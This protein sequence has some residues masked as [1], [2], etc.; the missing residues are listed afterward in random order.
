M[1]ASIKKTTVRP[2]K[3]KPA[4]ANQDAISQEIDDLAMRLVEGERQAL[5]KAITLIESTRGDHREKAETLLQR[6]MPQTGGAVRLG[7][8]GAP[9]VGKSTFV[10]AFG[11]YL[12]AHDLKVAVLAID[13]SS[14]RSGGSILGDKTRMEELARDSRAFIRPSPSG[15]SLGGV[16]RRT[17]ETLLLAEAAGFDVVIV[18]TV[19]VGQSETMVADMVD[20]FLLLLSPAGGDELQG[21]KRGIMELADLVIVTKADG[22]LIPAARRAAIQCKAALSFMQPKTEY[23]RAEVLTVSALKGQGMEEIWQ[24]VGAHHRSFTSTNA[25]SQLRAAQAVAA[26]WREVEETMLAAFKENPEVK[27]QVKLME[28]TVSGGTMTPSTAARQLLGLFHRG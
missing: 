16:A 4:M 20:M 15:G 8:S 12:T 13:P 19:G 2:N 7:L 17:R 1:T 27:S 5:A 22:E 6:L 3:L 10:E 9:G 18:E 21:I 23:W 28:K 11:K 14:K 24:R 26:L 25:L